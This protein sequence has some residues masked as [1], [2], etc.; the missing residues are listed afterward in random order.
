M[1]VFNHRRDL[2]DILHHMPMGMGR[3]HALMKF[4]RSA[5]ED[6]HKIYV[7]RRYC[8]TLDKD[9]DLSLLVKRGELKRV[10]EGA[11]RTR[12]TMLVLPSSVTH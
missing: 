4:M 8:R 6:A 5:T 9:T 12:T 10:R 2:Y 7:N 1:L 11:P 3:R